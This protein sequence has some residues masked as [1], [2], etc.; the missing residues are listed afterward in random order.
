MSSTE[1]LSF[2]RSLRSSWRDEEEE[3]THESFEYAKRNISFIEYMVGISNEGYGLSIS[4]AE[5]R[6]EGFVYFVGKNYFS[7]VHNF[8]S[9]TRLITTFP[10]KDELD[11]VIRVN[12]KQSRKD[13]ESKKISIEEKSFK[14]FLDEIALSKSECNLELNQEKQ[15]SGKIELF[16]DFLRIKNSKNNKE[17]FIEE[18]ST[19]FSIS[20]IV[21]VTTSEI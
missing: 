19:I 6:Y 1:N 16:K 21:A 15:V 13:G 3:L 10:I 9:K 11:F 12:K 17:N 2:A 14:A 7:L 4:T 20:S 5:N 18:D 8:E